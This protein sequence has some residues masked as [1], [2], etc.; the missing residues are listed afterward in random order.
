MIKRELG[1]HR[2][3]V[4]GGALS[5]YRENT[6]GFFITSLQILESPG[7]VLQRRLHHIQI[8]SVLLFPERIIVWCV[9][10]SVVVFPGQSE[11]LAL[12]PRTSVFGRA[13]LSSTSKYIPIIKKI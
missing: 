12:V 13:G 7:G 9:C 8:S 2:W 4:A 5:M 11:E 6:S 3:V 10:V 1:E